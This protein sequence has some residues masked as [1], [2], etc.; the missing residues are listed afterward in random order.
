[1]NDRPTAQELIEAA[2]LYLEKELLP[3]LSDARLRFQTLVAAN[4][5]SVAG[6]ELAGEARLARVD[7]TVNFRWDRESPTSD[8]VA[9]GE[10]PADRALANDDFSVRWTGQLLPPVSGRYEITVT[11]D[12]GFRLDVGGRRVIDEWTA[13]PRARAARHG[14]RAGGGSPRAAVVAV[15]VGRVPRRHARR[16]P[17]RPVPGRR[18][19]APPVRGRP[20]PAR[21]PPVRPARRPPAR[22]VPAR[23]VPRL[24]PRGHRA[25]APGHRHRPAEHAGPVGAARAPR[26]DIGPGTR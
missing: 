10:L 19:P 4:V 23:R 26:P 14:P 12:D 21:R 18:A 8:L 9:R 5:L 17:G 1:M 22:R 13:A 3:A 25:P 16:A 11:G 7:P 15:V 24:R 6:R 2:R 20:R